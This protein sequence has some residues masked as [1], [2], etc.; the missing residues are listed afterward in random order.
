[1]IRISQPIGLQPFLPSPEASGRKE[2]CGGQGVVSQ[3]EERLEG[4]SESLALPEEMVSPLKS[5]LL[6]EVGRMV[7]QTME[8]LASE[9]REATE[10]EE[11]EGCGRDGKEGL[12][13]EVGSQGGLEGRVS[14]A[15]AYLNGGGDAEVRGGQAERSGEERRKRSGEER[16][17]SRSDLTRAQDEVP[18]SSPCLLLP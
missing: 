9:A 11:W 5:H 4:R 17:S 1:M 7:R 10:R 14:E 2:E 12:E 8:E 13:G 6:G 15:S 3:V 18:R 16:R